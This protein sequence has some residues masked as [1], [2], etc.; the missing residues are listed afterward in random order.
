MPLRMEIGRLACCQMGGYDW[1]QKE[2][3][4]KEKDCRRESRYIRLTAVI[5]LS[6][7]LTGKLDLSSVDVQSRQW[8]LKSFLRRPE[9]ASGELFP[10]K[11]DI[12]DFTPKAV[13][14]RYTGTAASPPEVV[15]VRAGEEGIFAVRGVLKLQIP[16][17]DVFVWLTDPVETARIFSSHVAS[18]HH[19]KV[20]MDT[21]DKLKR[22]GFKLVEV[23]KTGRWRLLGISFSFESTVLV[24]EDWRKLRA[25]YKQKRPGAM[26]HFSGFWQVIPAGKR[27]SLV[28][29]YSEAIPGFPVPAL[30][31]RFA[32]GVL[33]TMA[34]SIL[35]ELQRAANIRRTPEL[36]SRKV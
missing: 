35:L 11:V 9:D 36:T 16:A 31:K 22:G 34:S 6:C 20:L 28:L 13:L 29:L 14:Q 19:R 15:S 32:R 12:S 1:C 5:L 30:L 17:H 2:I 26:K 8:K 33:E 24:R 3:Q 27:E 21:T 25:E 18:A 4:A 23:S 7:W 10:F